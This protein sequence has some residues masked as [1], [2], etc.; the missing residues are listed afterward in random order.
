MGRFDSL[1]NGDEPTPEDENIYPEGH[2]RNILANAIN[3]LELKIPFANKLGL[4]EQVYIPPVSKADDARY[5]KELPEQLATSFM[6][7]T[8]AVKELGPELGKLTNAAAGAIKDKFGEHLRNLDLI[9]NFVKNPESLRPVGSGAFKNVYGNEQQVLKKFRPEEFVPGEMLPQ[10]IQ[11]QLIVN[12]LGELAPKTNTYKTSNNVYQVQDKIQP[13]IETMKDNYHPD[14]EKM[15]SNNMDS[16]QTQEDYLKSLLNKKGFDPKSDY[17]LANP[18]N[19]GYSKLG[20][21]KIS[22]VGTFRMSQPNPEDIIK[23]QENYKTLPSDIDYINE[24]FKLKG[25]K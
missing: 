18:Y 17:D 20:D 12:K 4:N 7:E 25:Q 1:I 3:P 11:E 21:P 2:P 22:D 5:T 10:S 16:I 14:L 24:I 8:R 23:L 13:F 15:I 19:H 9:K 6:G